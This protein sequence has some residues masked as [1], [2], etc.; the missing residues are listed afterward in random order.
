M[1]PH[2]LLYLFEYY[3]ITTIGGSSSPHAC[4]EWPGIQIPHA[5][6]SLLD[7]SKGL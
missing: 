7:S 4:A 5:I 6:P 3:M 2:T 1:D